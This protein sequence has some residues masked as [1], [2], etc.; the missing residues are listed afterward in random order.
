VKLEMAR[1]G[2]PNG[3]RASND[4]KYGTQTA[5]DTHRIAYPSGIGLREI[6]RSYS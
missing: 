5:Q 4:W 6:E 3:S 2:G 1:R